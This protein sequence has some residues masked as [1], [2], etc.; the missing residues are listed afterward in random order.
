[1]QRLTAELQE[2]FAE[3]NQLQTRIKSNL[4]AL[5]YGR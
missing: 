1:M 2:H 3:A 5:G 4:E